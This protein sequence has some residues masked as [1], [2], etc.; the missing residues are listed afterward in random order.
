MHKL[1][2]LIFIFITSISYGQ[3][4]NYQDIDALIN[5]NSTIDALTAIRKLKE[6]H[7]KDSIDSGYWIRYSK[8][9]YTTYNYD[10]AKLGI[11]KAIKLDPN[12]ANT[13]FEKGLLH[14][15]IGE[16]QPA[17]FA[18]EKAVSIQPKG[19]YYYWKGI[20][21]QQLNNIKI[22]Q[23]D[24]QKALENNFKSPELYVNYAILLSRN[25]KYK[26]GLETIN[27][28]IEI[29]NKHP[30]AISTRAT[31]HFFLLNVDAACKDSHTALELGYLQTQQIPDS[32]CN[33]TSTQKFQFLADALAGNK[34]YKQSSIVYT[35]LIEN[36]SSNPRHFLNRGYCFYQLKEFKKAEKDYLKALTLPNPELDLL[37]DNLSLL[38]FDQQKFQKAIDYSSKR[39]ELNSKNHVAYL[40]RGLSY[41]KLKKYN[42]AEKDFEASLKIR[43]NFF[44]AYGYRAYL[45]ME[46][47]KNQDAFKDAEKAVEINPKYAYGYLMLAQAKQALNLPE[48]CND[49]FAAKKYG[50]TKEEVDFAIKKYCK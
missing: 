30:H 49:Y 35:Q 2:L 29:D 42:E 19:E 37:Y 14:N 10:N 22:A 3:K 6:N 16:L 50:W 11:D 44:R 27:K 25:Q 21:N 18:L 47:G 36:K 24:Y 12:N 5:K 28:A 23:N 9:S 32:I 34:H 39:I 48:F 41:R 4:T 7:A 20:V 13:Y 33:G 40:D 31:I 45:Y 15:R 46:Q 1:I 26:E 8:A 38:Y 43:P 17:L